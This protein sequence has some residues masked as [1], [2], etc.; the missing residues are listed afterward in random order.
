MAK[1]LLG[2][3]GNSYTYLWDVATA[4]IIGAFKDPR[5][6]RAWVVA[7]NPD[8]RLLAVGDQNGNIYVRVTS[9]LAA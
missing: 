6:E 5:G 3:D 4:K 7:F 8:G 9:Q 2:A 1:T